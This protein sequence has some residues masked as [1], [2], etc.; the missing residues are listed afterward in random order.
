[1]ETKEL[2]AATNGSR[3]LETMAER[4][5]VI[6]VQPTFPYAI[7]TPL[8]HNDNT[9]LIQLAVSVFQCHGAVAKRKISYENPTKRVINNKRLELL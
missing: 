9:K 1:M 8:Y 3:N 6:F 4:V 5:L 2:R 7:I